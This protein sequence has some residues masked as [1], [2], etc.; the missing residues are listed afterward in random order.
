MDHS[1]TTI[2]HLVLPVRDLGEAR[3][4][5]DALGFIVAPDALHPFGTENCCIFL[6][7]GAYLEPLGIADRII[8]E[9]EARAGNPFLRRDLAYRFRV[10]DEGMS[11]LAMRSDDAKKDLARYRAEGIGFSDVFEFSRT[12]KS[13]DKEFEISVK[14]AIAADD[15]APD[16]A[17]FGCQR[18]NMGDLWNAERTSHDNGVTGISAVLMCEEN[19]TDFQYILQAATGMRDYISSSNGLSFHMD[20]ADIFCFTPTAM[21]QLFSIPAARAERGLRFEGVVFTCTSVKKLK[22]RLDDQ[23]IDCF[24]HLDRLIV[25]TAPGQGIPFLFEEVRS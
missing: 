9:A 15:R 20:G 5:Y 23:G 24:L 12:A 14:L 1:P 3:Q 17:F 25:P 19:P 6:A 7:D 11:M 13:G 4:R 22:Q 2:D 16:A 10:D 18:S 21:E 8:A